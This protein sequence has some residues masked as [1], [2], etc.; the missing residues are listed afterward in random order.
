VKISATLVGAALALFCLSAVVSAESGQL[1]KL[2][3]GTND[4][5]AILNSFKVQSPITDE[6]VSTVFRGSLLGEQFSASYV[7]ALAGA[8]T[9]LTILSDGLSEEAVFVTG[10]LL[11]DL[12][13]MNSG[14]SAVPLRW[15]T[16]SSR[17]VGGWKVQIA[18]K[19][20]SSP[21]S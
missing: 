1:P 19:E 9:D 14:R 16:T 18:C 3:D 20:H 17:V 2:P 4:V 13:C 11:N 8:A 10:V 7:P 12:I 15:K 6:G 5:A 21:D